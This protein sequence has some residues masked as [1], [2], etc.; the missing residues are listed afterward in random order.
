MAAGPPYAA[1]PYGAH[2]IGMKIPGGGHGAACL[3]RGSGD[4]GSAVAHALKARGLPVA[5][6]DVAAPAYPRRGMAYVDALFDGAAL[7]EGVPARRVAD[8]LALRA[9]AFRGAAIP[10]FAGRLEDAL[11]TLGADVLVDARMRKRDAPEVQLG[12]AAL[13]LGLG[14]GFAAGDN[15][16]FAIETAWGE[17][18]GAVIG[19]GATLPLCGEPRMIL[20]H[21][22]ARFVYAPSAGQIH[23]ERSIGDP[24][25]RGE[26]IAR[27]AGSVLR[28]PFDGVLV[29]LTRPGVAV[30]EGAKVIEVDPRGE[31]SVAFGIGERGR[32]I[33][34]GVL[35]A[36]STAFP[37]AERASPTFRRSP[38]HAEMAT[39]LA[40]EA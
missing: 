36:I 40:G 28:A 19:R 34:Q 13:T 33:A 22:R 30:R 20:G 21:S 8:T 16:D 35:H 25:R 9:M 11:E 5:V 31:R 29:G 26:E 24:V 15:V 38:A 3:V 18:L 6:H 12:L 17:T 39:S 7:L 10:V 27:L 1:W 2:E 32:A 37:A 14:P 23:S 4:I